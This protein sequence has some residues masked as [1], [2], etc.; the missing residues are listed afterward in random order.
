MEAT[1]L[2]QAAQVWQFAFL[3]VTL[4]QSRVETVESEEDQ[5]LDFGMLVSLPAG[6]RA[7]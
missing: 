1:L 6:D 4:G 2:A 3:H 7:V 5:P